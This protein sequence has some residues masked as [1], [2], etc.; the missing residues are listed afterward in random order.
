MDITF[1]HK[2]P[3]EVIEFEAHRGTCRYCYGIVKM[4][5]DLLTMRVCPDEC[6]CLQCGQ[7]YAV[8]VAEDIARWEETQWLQ[9]AFEE[10]NR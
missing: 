3:I 5:R 10:E 7:R 9:K 8:V 4:K 2:A 6:W 1:R